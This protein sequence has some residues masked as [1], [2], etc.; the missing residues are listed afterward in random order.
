MIYCR[1]PGIDALPPSAGC[2]KEQGPVSGFLPNTEST[3]SDVQGGGAPILEPDGHIYFL[4]SWASYYST[5]CILSF[6]VH[7]MSIV[8]ISIVSF[9]ASMS[10]EN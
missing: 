5:I 9:E 10:Y 8:V 2:A 3:G 1:R 4:V 7:N 6:L